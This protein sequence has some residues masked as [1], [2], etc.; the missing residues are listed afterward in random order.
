MSQAPQLKIRLPSEIKLFI[1]K[2]AE[3][4]GSTL[5]SEVIRA[6][7]EKMDRTI[8]VDRR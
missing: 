8:V 6:I 3:N 4:N 2:Q 5:N 1:A 7:R